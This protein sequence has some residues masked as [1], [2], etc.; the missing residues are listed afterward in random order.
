MN[1]SYAGRAVE[2]SKPASQLKHLGP[3]RG[4]IVDR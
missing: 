1:V 4:R 3:L 2:G